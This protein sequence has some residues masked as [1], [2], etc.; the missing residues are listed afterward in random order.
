MKRNNKK[1]ASG[2]LVALF[3]AF[4]FTGSVK[5]QPIGIHEECQDGIDNDGEGDIDENDFH[6]MEYPFADGAGESPTTMGESGKAFS[7][8]SYEM[9]L[10]EYHEDNTP[11]FIRCFR[12][13]IYQNA[14]ILSNGLEGSLSQYNEWEIANCN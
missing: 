12:P 14:D 8:D 3:I 7:S 2:F 1:M 4:A 9:T 10:F 6:C 5:A 11:W 13:Q